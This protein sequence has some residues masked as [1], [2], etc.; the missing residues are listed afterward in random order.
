M[1]IL[2][3]QA[4]SDAADLFDP[5]GDVQTFV[6]RS[7]TPSDLTDADALIVRSV[8]RVDEAL[9]ADSPV[10][11]VGSPTS[12]TDH[13]DT[14]C[15]ARRGIAFT[16]APGCNA[17]PV[18]EYVLTAICLQILKMGLRP[19]ETTL[20]VVGLGRIGSIVADWARP[21]GL[22]VLQNDPPRQ[23]SGDPGPWTPLADLLAASDCVTL[24]V[25]LSDTSPDPTHTLLDASRLARIKPGAIL[26]NTARG[27]VISEAD[28][29]AA[30]SA[31]RP[32]AAVLDVWRNEPHIRP[33]LATRVEIATPHI[34]GQSV[35]ARRRGM[36]TVIHALADWAGEV[37]NQWHRPPAGGKTGE[38]PVPQSGALPMPAQ[39][40]PVYRGFRDLPAVADALDSACGLIKIDTELRQAL[41]RPDAA[42]RFDALRATFARR[43]EFT[44][45]TLDPAA[46]SPPARD[47]LTAVGFRV[48]PEN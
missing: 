16:H 38:P 44:A 9:L 33:D 20:G 13:I 19:S 30:L 39:E 31:G 6:G 5:L 29:L 46:F 15:L 37:T 4:L 45:H 47:F 11:F 3:D 40:A 18:A 22:T 21:L 26:I 35:E 34:A 27:E 41:A 25:P 8:T 10:Q 28:L 23:R 7:L 1:R 17:R 48:N 32:L 24:H 43:R 14:A 12:G 36:A 42:R 2:V